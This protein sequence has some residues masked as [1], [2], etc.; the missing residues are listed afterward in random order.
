MTELCIERIEKI[1]QEETAKME[2]L[3]TIVRGIYTKPRSA[4]TRGK[5]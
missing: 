1:L 4:K 2:E 5:I 3:L